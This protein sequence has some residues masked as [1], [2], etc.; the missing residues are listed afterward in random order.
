M[1]KVGKPT[2]RHENNDPR[3]SWQEV[4]H[5]LAVLYTALGELR[6]PEFSRQ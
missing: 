1:R 2:R 5:F 3:L 4:L 6:K